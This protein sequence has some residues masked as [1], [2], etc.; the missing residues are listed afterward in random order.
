MLTGIIIGLI[1]GAII[2]FGVAAFLAFHAIIL[3]W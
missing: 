3:P 2:G 1:I